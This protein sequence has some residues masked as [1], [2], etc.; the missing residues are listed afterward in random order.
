[1]KDKV[2]YMQIDRT[3]GVLAAL[4][5]LGLAVDPIPVV[6][7]TTHSFPKRRIDKI[8]SMIAAIKLRFS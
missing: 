3:K 6:G 2:D 7:R 5:Y 1:M 8:K 4:D